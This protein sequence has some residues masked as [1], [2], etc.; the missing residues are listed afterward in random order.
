MKIAARSRRTIGIALL[1]TTAGGVVPTLFAFVYRAHAS[2][3][4]LCEFF[5]HSIVY[6]FCI[7]TPCF[8][9]MPAMSRKARGH[10]AWF[11]AVFL[12][13]LLAMAVVGSLAANLI[14]LALD[15]CSA[16]GFWADFRDGL[17]IAI[18]ITL[19][20]GIVATV[21]EVL[22]SRLRTAKLELQARQLDEERA[23]KREV[24]A[25][26]SSLESRIHPHF[27]FNTLNSI[28]ALIREDPA[29]AERT[30][31]RLAALLRYSLDTSVKPV[32][33]IRHELRLVEDYLQIDK[34]RFGER[35]R[36]SIDVPAP[37]EDLEVQ[38]LTLQTVVENS[39][40]HVVSGSRHGGEIRISARLEA[41]CLLLDITDDGPGFEPSALQS[42]HGLDNLRE[43]ITAL[44]DGA[45]RLEFARGDGRMMVSIAVPQ[46]KVLE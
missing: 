26:L 17:R 20:V 39:L 11:W 42:G 10:H 33:P 19:L 34:T 36:Y 2:G 38:P 3:P 31:E 14:F 24:Q 41:G 25:R 27:L 29:R 18:A 9:A 32:I 37:L 1:V 8:L 21:I 16:D 4:F 28:S 40:K 13:V 5:R 45:G 15:W 22:S 35:L 46:K 43:R 12:A 7:G 6:S 30:V 44:F 23:R